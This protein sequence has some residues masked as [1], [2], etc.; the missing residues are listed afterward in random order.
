MITIIQERGFQF[1]WKDNNEIDVLDDHGNLVYKIEGDFPSYDS[2]VERANEY[3][4]EAE[5]AEPCD[6]CIYKYWVE[7]RSTMVS[8]GWGCEL[9]GGHAVEKCNSFQEES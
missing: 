2:V 3:L 5:A 7:S 1:R 8:S 9:S 6:G 4:E